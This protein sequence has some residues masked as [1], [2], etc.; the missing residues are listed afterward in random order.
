MGVISKSMHVGKSG[1]NFPI[2]SSVLVVLL[3]VSFVDQCFLVIF[4]E[5]EF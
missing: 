2:L 4:H 1:Y 5:Q 3:A